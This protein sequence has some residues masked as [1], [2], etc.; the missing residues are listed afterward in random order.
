MTKRSI[1]KLDG[2]HLFG[3][4]VGAALVV[5]SCEKIDIDTQPPKIIVVQPDD[6]S[7]FQV[8][9]DFLV[10]TVMHDYVALDS[11]RYNVYWFDDPSNSSDNP[12][13][14]TFE[15]DRTEEIAVTDSAPHWED[16][17]FRIDIPLNI[18]RGYYL[19]DIYCYDKA[20]NFDKVSLKVLF[21]D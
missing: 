3:L 1:I 15:L 12:D 20:A 11:Y 13:D 18:R 5:S 9:T 4:L 7:T 19:L 16:V 21:Q 10:V 14:E 2:L 8:G 6:N 17:N